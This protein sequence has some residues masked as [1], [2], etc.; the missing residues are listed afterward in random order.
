MPPVYGLL[1]NM[2]RNRN[3]N[4]LKEVICEQ[5]SAVQSAAE[6]DGRWAIKLPRIGTTVVFH[7]EGDLLIARVTP[8]QAR[9]LAEMSMFDVEDHERKTD[10]LPPVLD[11]YAEGERLFKERQGQTRSSESSLTELLKGLG[12]ESALTSALADKLAA[13]ANEEAERLASERFAREQARKAEL[14][15]EFGFVRLS[16]RL[17]DDQVAV[18]M[19]TFLVDKDPATMP[20]AARV[21]AISKA[22]AKD[23]NLQAA[24]RDLIGDYDEE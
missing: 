24:I 23:T 5:Y 15:G 7:L 17:L 19:N 20:A 10:P 1:C 3:R 18:L 11:F 21:T 9:I 2:T 14:S 22:A 4:D 6:G 8:E 16:E 12:L 13:R